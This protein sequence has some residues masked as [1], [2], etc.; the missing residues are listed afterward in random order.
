V[1]AVLLKSTFAV[2][3][4]LKAGTEVSRALEM[5]DV[6][7]AQGELRSLVSRDVGELDRRLAASAAIE[8]LAENAVDSF[9]APWLCY[10]AAGLPGAFAYRALNTLDSMWGYRNNEY[11]YLGK[12]AARLDDAVNY[13]PA[14]LAP[15]L[16]LIVGGLLGMR[17]DEG[18]RML[19]RDGGKTESPNAGRP[20]ST[21][22]GL[23]GVQLEKPGAYRL[24][25]DIEPVDAGRIAQAQR[26]V[27]ATAVLGLG[28][29][30]LLDQLTTG[31][32]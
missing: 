5:E 6:A 1:E 4:L 24:G 11:E 19:R 21:M 25:D 15:R 29:A 30:I 32:R 28:C 22:A 23:L 10:L 3:G 27:L 12:A 16:M 31:R 9:L 14:A 26:V 7:A 17:T 8:S 13:L 2:R 20:M 18:R